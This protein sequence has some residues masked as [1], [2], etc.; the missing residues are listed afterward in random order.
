MKKAWLPH[1]TIKA[2]EDLDKMFFKE[3][4]EKRGALSSLFAR[5]LTLF[6]K[7]EKKSI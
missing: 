2:R 4:K 7:T 1:Y 6:S 3:S 5:F